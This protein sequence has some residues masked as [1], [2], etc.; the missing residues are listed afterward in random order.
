[1]SRPL[2]VAPGAA[3]PSAPAASSAPG[4]SPGQTRVDAF[5]I[6]QAWVPA[7]T[8]QMGTDAAAIALLSAAGP[9]DW[10]ASEFPSEG[11]KHEVRLTTGYWIDRTEVTNRAFAAFAAAGG[12][13][14]QAHWSAAGWA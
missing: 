1:M 9:P 12:Y 14:T 11:P 13:T 3:S 10:V 8:F 4:S 7:G 2:S 5:G 6:E